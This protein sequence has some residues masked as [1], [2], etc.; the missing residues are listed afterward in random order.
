MAA[1]AALCATIAVGSIALAEARPRVERVSVGVDGQPNRDSTSPLVS[2]DGRYVA[3]RSL[4]STLVENDHNG[5]ADIFVRDR[6]RGTTQRVIKHV[7]EASTG[8]NPFYFD[9]QLLGWIRNLGREEYLL[10]DLRT[11]DDV[12]LNLGSSGQPVGLWIDHPPALSRDARTFAFT[13]FEAGVV[14]GFGDGQIDAFVRDRLAGTVAPVSIAVGGG[15]PN[16]NSG[17]PSISADGQ[18]IGF[19]SAASDLV[20]GDTNGL[21]DVFVHDRRTG[22]TERV[23]VSSAAAQGNRGEG[24]WAGLGS[25]L[26]AVSPD[27]HLVAYSSSASN[28][29]PRD[30]NRAEDVFVHDRRTRKTHRISITS[31]DRQATGVHG[32]FAPV[33]VGPRTVAFAS[34][35]TNLVAGDR[36]RHFDH[37]LRDFPR[38]ATLRA[39]VGRGRPATPAAFD[40]TYPLTMSANGL[41]VTFAAPDRADVRGDSNAAADVFV[42]GPLERRWDLTTANR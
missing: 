38:H 20:A 14:P 1:S 22:A 34:N 42:Y 32:S 11:G 29:V 33:F 30:T 27:G 16:G 10:R 12:Q 6:L 18:V 17:A 26:A 41:W 28:L 40:W 35:A 9:G 36:N 37:F 7:T 5:R 21:S 31:R 8:P 25:R 39:A 24:R 15:Q 13:S 3:F 19:E 4:A 23:S 2:P